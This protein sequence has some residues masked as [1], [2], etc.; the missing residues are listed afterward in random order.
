MRYLH[1]IA[2]ENDVPYRK[3]DQPTP[4][5]MAAQRAIDAIDARWED[6]ETAIKVLRTQHT[7]AAALALAQAATNLAHAYNAGE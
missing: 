6:M 3:P 4:K 5:Q 1:P 7:A 2:W